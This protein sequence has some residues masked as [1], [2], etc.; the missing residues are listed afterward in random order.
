MEI[1]RSRNWDNFLKSHSSEIRVRRQYSEIQI[2]RSIKWCRGGTKTTRTVYYM[3]HTCVLI[4]TYI[5]LRSNE[6]IYIN[7]PGSVQRDNSDISENCLS[8]YP[9]FEMSQ[10]LKKLVQFFNFGIFLSG[11]QRVLI[12]TPNIY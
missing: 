5:L 12:A 4:S 2:P 8:V 6:W 9:D 11:T 10:F 1:S 3:Q 7:T